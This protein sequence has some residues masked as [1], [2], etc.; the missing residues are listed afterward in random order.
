M[1]AML[2]PP[3]PMVRDLGWKQ[4]LGLGQGNDAFWAGVR[5]EQLVQLARNV[6]FNITLLGLNLAV[7][8]GVFGPAVPAVALM[9]FAAAIALLAM[10]WLLRALS[11]E[12]QGMTAAT[13]RQY[14]KVVAE[15]TLLGLLWGGMVIVL[16]PALPADS[17]AVLMLFSLLFLGATSNCAGTLA[18]AVVLLCLGI[19]GSML[20]A[21][22]AGT[23]MDHALVW[24]AL[25]SF[26][27]VKLRAALVTTWTMMARLK[28]EAELQ[29]QGEVVRLLLN[30]YEANGS[31]WLLELDALGRLSHVTP[32][33]ADVAR[34]RPADM[35][36]Q[37]LLALLDPVQSGA[38]TAAL[39]HA[40]AARQPFRDLVVPVPLG[41]ELRW[42]SLSGTPRFAAGGVFA[43]YRGVGRD[44]TDA[45]RAHERIAQLARFDPLTGL[46]NRSLFREVLDEVVERASRGRDAAALLFVD[47]DRFKAVND[48]F[49][50]GAGDLLL[51]QVAQRLQALVKPD[52]AT[53]A[54]LG[55]DEFAVVLA[56]SDEGQVAALA[57]RIVCD[58]A[59][60]FA[61]GESAAAGSAVIGASVGWACAPGDASTPEPLLKC[62][63][64]ALYRA[65]E[66]GRGAARRF[67]PDLAEAAAQRRRLEADLG[68]ALARGQLALAFQPIVDASDERITGF[69]ALL[70]WQHPELG[71]VPPLD[72][73]PLAE[74]TGL[75]VPIGHWIIDAAL[76]QAARWPDAIGIAVNLSAVQVEDQ[77][78]PEVIAA[79]LARHGIAAS[80][81]ELEITESLF[82]AEK[83]AISDVLARL[84]AMGVCFALDDFGTGYSA[85][86]T[87]KKASFS[88]IKIDRSFVSRAVAMGDEASA[89]IQAIVGLAASLDMATTAEGTETRAAFELVRQL[90]CSQAQGYLFGKPMPPD[91]ATRPSLS[92]PGFVHPAFQQRVGNGQRRRGQ[93]IAVAGQCRT[94]VILGDPAHFFQLFLVQP[95]LKAVGFG[96]GRHHQAG[97]EGPRLAGQ[98]AHPARGDAGFFPQFATHRLLQAF[99]RFHKAGQRRQ[100]TLGEAR[101]P[102]DQG[103][104]ILDGQHDHHRI[105]ARE[106]FGLAA[107]AAA[108]IAGL[109]QHGG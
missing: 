74:E 46:A 90:G 86:G 49:G 102:A 52:G 18:P 71:Q 32:R 66:D 95:H 48:C 68:E 106:M 29:E 80:R 72:F 20:L 89:I 56:A 42:W 43:G 8:M 97:G 5:A 9:P 65:K 17:Q 99:A 27:A 23:P 96:K 87:L 28:T 30:E 55:G 69:E 54:R 91:D 81:L 21:V 85:L 38:T 4:V 73:I 2:V 78:L 109:G 41:R 79:A 51:R 13:Q 16:L 93:P 14:W 39:T 19:G 1:T 108:G 11:G 104:A 61:L 105:D 58:L 70:R 75:I 3:V 63:D 62:A 64:L 6:P 103:V 45:R 98:I 76:A 26:V 101:L 100:E 24:L 88:R 84:T 10:L 82:L 60:P 67:T 107:R 33:F 50:H 31:D 53:I 47:L 40:M 25:G 12:V 35:A 22:P 34:R 92:I 7:V 37:P 57:N 77:S 83:P 59:Q 15:V 44:V 36:G 94:H